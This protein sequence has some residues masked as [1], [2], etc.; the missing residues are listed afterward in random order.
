MHEAPPPNPRRSR[1]VDEVGAVAQRLAG[2]HH[3]YCGEL[4]QWRKGRNSPRGTEGLMAVVGPRGPWDDAPFELYVTTVAHY[5][6]AASDL[7]GGFGSLCRTGADVISPVL[8]ARSCFDHATRA[9]W[10][11][12]PRATVVRRVARAHLEYLNGLEEYGEV[13]PRSHAKERNELKRHRKVF[14]RKTIPDRFASV[15]GALPARSTV[16]EGENWLDV[17]DVAKSFDEAVGAL[18]SGQRYDA[19]AAVSKPNSVAL[20]L[21]AREFAPDPATARQC[22]DADDATALLRAIAT[23]WISAH[24]EWARYNAWDPSMLEGLESEINAL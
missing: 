24:L 18:R 11:L 12:D 1:R 9:T 4:N 8:L 15:D 13:M 14:R 16:I 22:L 23:V 2:A 3:Y 21:L 7:L 10:L 6:T 5:L 17:S 19:F 20:Q